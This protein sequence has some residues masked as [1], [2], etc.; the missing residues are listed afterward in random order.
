MARDDN[1]DGIGR[2]R[3]SRWQAWKRRKPGLESPKSAQ[4]EPWSWSLKVSDWP[5]GKTSYDLTADQ[6]VSAVLGLGKYY[7][8]AM[9]GLAKAEEQDDVGGTLEGEGQDQ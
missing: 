7:E 4:V 9:T 1:P 2:D 3:P 5:I 6:A 8:P